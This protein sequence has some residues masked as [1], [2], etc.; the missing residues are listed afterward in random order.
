M[1]TYQ[2]QK[3]IKYYIIIKLLKLSFYNLLFFNYFRQQEYDL[4]KI[5]PD[6]ESFLYGSHYSGPALL[7]YFLIRIE[8]FS[9]L[10][11]KL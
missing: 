8:P 5:E 3:Y 6:Q 4:C 10:G 7:T 11:H 2:S 1:H 9:F